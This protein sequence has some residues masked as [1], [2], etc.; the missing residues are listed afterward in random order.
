[1]AFPPTFE[2]RGELAPCANL[3]PQAV[4]LHQEPAEQGL[5]AP[6][7]TPWR[8]HGRRGRADTACLGGCGVTLA[9]LTRDR[10]RERSV[11]PRDRDHESLYTLPGNRGRSR[12]WRR[13]HDV[14]LPCR[15]GESRRDPT[16]QADHPRHYS[17][18]LAPRHRRTPRTGSA[19]TWP[20]SPSAKAVAST[21]D[22]GADVAACA[23]LDES[24]RVL[25]STAQDDSVE[26][27]HA[28]CRSSRC[29]VATRPRHRVGLATAFAAPPSC[30]SCNCG[31]ALVPELARPSEGLAAASAG[32]HRHV[33]VESSPARPVIDGRP[34]TEPP[35][36]ELDERRP[37][38]LH[39]AHARPDT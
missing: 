22:H 31:T 8:G 34:A 23:S 37:G 29:T 11:L 12:V 19:R 10:R 36:G 6:W 14:R 26:V 21:R 15:P 2:V 20:V 33:G 4:D 39:R 35:P 38:H 24:A 1:V 9:G 32:C 16:R 13:R 27:P 30:R 5:V 3:R 17:S 28:C 18:T 7:A 25:R